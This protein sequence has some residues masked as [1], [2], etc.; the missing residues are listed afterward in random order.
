M[1]ICQLKFGYG[2]QK[3]WSLRLSGRRKATKRQ[4]GDC[5]TPQHL[6]KTLKAREFKFLNFKIES[7]SS[8]LVNVCPMATAL[9]FLPFVTKFRTFCLGLRPQGGLSRVE[10]QMCRSRVV[11]AL[12]GVCRHSPGLIP[13]IH[14]AA[15]HFIPRV[16]RGGCAVEPPEKGGGE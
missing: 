1:C 5:F 10:S 16:D 9:C 7:A 14:H 15:P 3:R 8:S 2:E 12:R 13:T 6:K 4:V 11:L